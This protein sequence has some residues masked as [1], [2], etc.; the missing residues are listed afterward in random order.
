MPYELLLEESSYGMGGR[1]GEAM[2]KVEDSTAERKRDPRARVAGT[3]VAEDCSPVVVG[4]DSLPLKGGEGRLTG[5][6]LRV[7]RLQVGKMAVAEAETD[8]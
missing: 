8:R 2:D 4:G 3:H 5:G 6:R 7:L 1:M